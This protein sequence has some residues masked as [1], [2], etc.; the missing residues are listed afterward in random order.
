MR[1]TNQLG[2]PIGD[3]LPDFRRTLPNLERIEGQ[4][5]VIECLSKDKHGA[6][7]RSVWSGFSCDMWTLSFQKT[8]PKIRQN[9]HKLDQM[10]AAQDRFTMRLI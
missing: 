3:A 4:Y 10:L 1:F 7:L 5:V 8:S 2:Q 6:D 9:G